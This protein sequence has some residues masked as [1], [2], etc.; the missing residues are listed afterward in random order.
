MPTFE[1]DSPVIIGMRDHLATLVNQ[2]REAFASRESTKDKPGKGLQKALSLPLTD[3]ETLY[4]DELTDPL[5]AVEFPDEEARCAVMFAHLSLKLTQLAEHFAEQSNL[6]VSALAAVPTIVMEDDELSKLS[7]DCSKLFQSIIDF[8]DSPEAAGQPF[9]TKGGGKGHLLNIPRFH[10]KP[11]DAKEHLYLYVDGF[12]MNAE[13]K[14]PY[15]NRAVD[16]AFS[17]KASLF[18]K[19]I[20]FKPMDSPVDFPNPHN[21]KVHQVQWRRTSEVSETQKALT[22]TL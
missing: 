6:F 18:L 13:L 15:V 5:M 2:Y 19:D 4:L 21:G 14:E 22:I 9:T 12:L 20:P 8:T 7:Q 10:N 16:E 3:T 1:T 17:V 11:K